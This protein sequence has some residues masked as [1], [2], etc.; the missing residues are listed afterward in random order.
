[1]ETFELQLRSL[2][3]LSSSDPA[4]MDICGSCLHMCSNEVLEMAIHSKE[5]PYYISTSLL[6]V[7]IF[8][9]ILF[10]AYV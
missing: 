1:M 7:F 6:L 3:C 9:H 5:T 8:L 4:L 2:H 10:I